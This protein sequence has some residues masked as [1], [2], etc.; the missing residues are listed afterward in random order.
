MRE[1]AAFIEVRMVNGEL[2]RMEG[3]VELSVFLFW[4]R[5]EKRG[6][7]R[8]EERGRRTEV[9][10]IIESVSRFSELIVR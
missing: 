9:H 5:V 7:G 8:T 2:R 10:V 3:G 1:R 6:R 4:Q